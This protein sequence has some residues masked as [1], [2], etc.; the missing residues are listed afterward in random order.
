MS[1]SKRSIALLRLVALLAVAGMVITGCAPVVQAP[2]AAPAANQPAAEAPAAAAAEPTATTATAAQPAAGTP[3]RGGTLTWARNAVPENLDVAWTEANQDTWVLVNVVEPLIRISADGTKLEPAVA[4]KYEM[5]D[6][7]LSYTFHI[8]PDIKF[9]DGTP[10]TADDVV[11]SIQRTASEGN[12]KWT[13]DNMQEIAKVDDATV[14]ITLKEKSTAFLSDLA[15]LNNAVLSKAAFD[16]MGKDE[17]MKHPIGT[18][19]FMISD[20][21]VGDHITLVKN[22]NYWEM[23]PDG[24]PYPYLDQVT[25]TQVPEDTTRV[26]QVQSGNVDAT[27][28]IPFSQIDSLK[29]DSKADITLW[30]STQSYYI[31]LN[32]RVPPLD[33]PKIR[34]AMNY[35]VD[36]QAMVDAVLFGNGSIATSF[37]PKDSLCWNSDLPGFPYDLEKAKQLVKESKYPDGFSGLKLEVPSGRQIGRDNATM[38]KDMWAKIGINVDIA[39]V[40][41]GLLSDEFQNNTFQAISGYQWTNDIIDP[42]EQVGW[43][44][45]DPAFHSGWKNDK[46]VELAKQAAIETDTAKRCEM[47]GQIQQIFN[48]DSPAILLYHTPFTTFI[49][50]DVKDFFQIP[51][52]WLVFG[53]V[54]IDR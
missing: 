36:R 23:A 28:A 41:G 17:F 42:D 46:A 30:T 45:V 35:A 52:G 2:A 13:L 50:K 47:Y 4:D 40:E 54:W 27:D 22:P 39:E 20:W 37:F 24:Q 32:N 7:G 51:L 8:R 5:A 12:W 21:V 43:F 25:L 18:G 29:N 6:D 53:R 26:L 11:F 9:S 3:K 10:V 38:L 31:F 1:H 16:K 34:L 48:E 33:D 14:K 49:N 19:P 44:V 15:L